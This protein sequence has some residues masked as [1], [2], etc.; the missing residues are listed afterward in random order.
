MCERSRARGRG[1]TR[2]QSGEGVLLAAEGGLGAGQDLA[3]RR[4]ALLQ[5]H[6]VLQLLILQLPLPVVLSL[7][8]GARGEATG[9]RWWA[10]RRRR[11]RFVDPPSV[12]KEALD[13]APR[14]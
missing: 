4:H 9:R 13:L 14:E 6:E 5:L 2:E 10:G 1:R 11:V 12:C 3:A 7:R 8:W